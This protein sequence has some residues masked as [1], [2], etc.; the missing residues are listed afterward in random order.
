MEETAIAIQVENLSKE[1]PHSQGKKALTNISF[2]VPIGKILCLLGPNGSGK[3][4]LL[5]I[6]AGLLKPSSGKISIFGRDPQ[7]NPS[8]T[9]SQIGWMPADEKSGFYG[10]LTGMQNLNFFSTFYNIGPQNRDRQIGNL[11]LQLD[12]TDELEQMMLKLSSGI[13]QK[14]GILRSLL[15]NPPVL[16]LDEPFRHLDPHGTKRLRRLL[17]DHITRTQKKTVILSTHQLEEAR[18]IA[19]IILV[20]KNGELISQLT[21]LELKHE[22]QSISLEDFYLKTIDKKEED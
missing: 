9:R 18:R 5:K 14:V 19:D 16:L 21:A 15:H 6:L 2:Q 17:R 10:R 1:Y 4:T 12:M 22:L 7:E 3:T 11:A 13:K 8:L 20:L